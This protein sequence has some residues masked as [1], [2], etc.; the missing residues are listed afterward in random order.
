[1][2]VHSPHCNRNVSIHAPYAGSDEPYPMREKMLYVSIHAPYAGS[3]TPKE[4]WLGLSIVSIHAP[5]AGSDDAKRNV[6]NLVAQ[7]Q[8]TPPMQGATKNRMFVL[9][10]T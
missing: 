4:N 1:M 7:F 2:V 9:L 10:F 6:K 8:S 3:D 5:Y